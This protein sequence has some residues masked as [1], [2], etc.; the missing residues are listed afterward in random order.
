MATDSFGSEHRRSQVWDSDADRVSP[1]AAERPLGALVSEFLEQGRHL[2]RAELTLARAE[3]RSEARKAA[4]G[5][6]MLAAGGLVLLLGAMA[7]VAFLVIVL[8]NVMPLWASALLVTVVL[9]AAGAGSAMVGV[10]RLKAVHA[11]HKTIQ[12]LKEDSQWASTTM[13]S[14]KSQ[15]HGHA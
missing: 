7:L 8:A 5:G 10:R 14:A 2:F 13:R 3:V 12:T 6:G 4:A 1:G 15:M 11:P 9:L